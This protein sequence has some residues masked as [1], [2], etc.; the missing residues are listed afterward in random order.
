MIPPLAQIT[1]AM[2]RG[3]GSAVLRTNT[4]LFMTLLEEY[5]FY[6]PLLSQLQSDEGEVA[7]Q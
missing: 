7:T 1:K 6:S 2:W 4:E 5:L 3:P